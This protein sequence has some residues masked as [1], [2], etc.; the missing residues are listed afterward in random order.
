MG[1]LA[2]IEFHAGRGRLR[3]RLR[4]LF[5]GADLCILLDGGDRPHIGA[6]ALMPDATEVRHADQ[7]DQE[8]PAALALELPGH[9]EGDLARRMAQELGQTLGHA[10]T[11]VC[12]IHMDAASKAD[13]ALALT[14]AHELTQQLTRI[15]TLPPQDA[16]QGN[17]C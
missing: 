4:A 6:V 16:E 8:D 2:M 17:T 10:V 1:E 12:G 9:R 15:L 14:L 11:V 13:I 7:V 5:M 3:L